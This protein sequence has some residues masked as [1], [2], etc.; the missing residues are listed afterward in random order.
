MRS[1]VARILIGAFALLVSI[2]VAAAKDTR[3]PYANHV[4]MRVQPNAPLVRPGP[5]GV[6]QTVRVTE[7]RCIG[8]PLEENRPS[9]LGCGAAMPA[10]SVE[11][12]VVTANCPVS[13]TATEAGAFTI[14]RTGTGGNVTLTEPQ[15]APIRGLCEIEFRDAGNRAFA[16]LFI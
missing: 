11:A 2:G 12:H 8:T 3:S 13:V 14:T 1:P 6:A 15:K 9:G 10:T 16:T 5:I 7:A 4:V